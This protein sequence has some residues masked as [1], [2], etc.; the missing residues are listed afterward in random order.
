MAKYLK[1]R[2]SPENYKAARTDEK[3]GVSDD[4]LTAIGRKTK[5]AESKVKKEM[6]LFSDELDGDS[7]EP[8]VKPRVKVGK[9]G[10]K[11]PIK[12]GVTVP[13]TRVVSLD[14]DRKLSKKQMESLSDWKGRNRGRAVD[15]FFR[16][17]AETAR[18]KF[19]HKS[20]YLGSEADTL[21]IGIPMFGG[22]GP[23]A[24]KYPG[25]L[26]MEF[27]IANDCF[28]LGLVIQL[29]GKHGVCK[30]ALL[31]E[32]GR[33][34]GL[35]GGGMTLKEVEDKFNSLWYRSIMGSEL[36]D[37]MPM[38][39]CKSVED[40]QRRLTH[41]ISSTKEAMLGT[42]EK[43][44]PGRIIPVLFG[45]DSI[46]GKQSEETQETI[47][48][49]VD[50]RTGKRGKTGKGH[51]TRGH[52][53]EALVITRYMRTIPGELDDWPFGM[54][55][56]NHLRVNKDEA[57]NQ[58]RSKAGGVQVNFQESFE[59]EL[60]KLGGH[61]K[62][63]QGKSFDGIPISIS[64]EKNSYGPTHRAIRTRVLWWEE[65]IGKNEW[66]QKTV[67]DWDWS[68]VDLLNNL[69]HGEGSNPRIKDSLAEIDFHLDCPTSSDIE[70]TAW[71]KTLGMTKDDA[72]SW[73]EVG[74]MIRERPKL[75]NRLR[76][77]L[78]INRRPLLAGD[79][80]EQ[81]EAVKEDLT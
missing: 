55:L 34:F 74:A 75:M 10:K 29:V 24:A 36:Y 58:E 52:P 11:T 6:D 71:S 73:S 14:E 65:D 23:D 26:P 21:L 64:C 39:K 50:K 43:P 1:P 38:Q 8:M 3:D 35:A 47:L 72:C 30:S 54:A 66:E 18:K 63:I 78:R 51:A 32:F 19:G 57:G 40:W 77:A 42:K 60:R 5:K 48:G 53:V 15:L 80:L 79:Y 46:M 81:L 20:V 4:V 49:K 70:N 44:G 27:V 9:D 41:D 37:M 7:A 2:K 61:K 45:V 22:H 13:K 62:K 59:L 12:A 56:V 17:Q 16:R 33:W 31:A 25:C 67:F 28:P 68:T 76:K 69:M